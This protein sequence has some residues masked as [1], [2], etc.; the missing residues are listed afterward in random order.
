ML[1]WSVH[2]VQFGPQELSHAA[3][4]GVHVVDVCQVEGSSCRGA[5]SQPWSRPR[6]LLPGSKPGLPPAWSGQLKLQ[7]EGAQAG[8][9]LEGKDEDEADANDTVETTGS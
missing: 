9:L 7:V 4:R 2:W 5:D 1:P 6:P 3:A 8:P